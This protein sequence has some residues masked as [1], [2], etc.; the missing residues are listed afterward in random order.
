MPLTMAWKR[1]ATSW[2]IS[3]FM[4]RTVP[5]SSASA[6]ITL[7]AVP[8]LKRATVTTTR[9]PGGALRETMLCS[10]CTICA[11]T[12]IGSIEAWGKAACAP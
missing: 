5:P 12:T 8:A 10:A 2:R 9:S 3:S 11:P 1:R 6:G 7:C 4:L